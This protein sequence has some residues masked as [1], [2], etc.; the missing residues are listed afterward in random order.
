[1]IDINK[2][3]LL[4]IF[5]MKLFCVTTTVKITFSVIMS[6]IFPTSNKKKKSNKTLVSFPFSRKIFWGIEILTAARHVLNIIKD[7]LINI[8]TSLSVLVLMISVRIYSPTCVPI[9]DK[10]IAWFLYAS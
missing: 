7:F 3:V 9:N 4:L 8:S 1:M 6:I 10:L 2:N 5:I